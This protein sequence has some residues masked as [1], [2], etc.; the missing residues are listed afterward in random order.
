MTL[1]SLIQA[2]A[3]NEKDMYYVSSILQN[4]L[5]SDNIYDYAKLSLDST[6]YYPYRNAKAVPKALGG[7]KFKSTY[8]TYNF[9]GLPIGPICNPGEAAI[10]AALNPNDTDYYYFCHDQSTGEPY[11]A[12]SFDEHQYN[13]SL[14]GL[15]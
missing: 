2:E 7:K 10:E 1:A 5:K 13:L 6:I 14:A 8:D 9:T 3:A 11:Y 15:V 12:S 4:R